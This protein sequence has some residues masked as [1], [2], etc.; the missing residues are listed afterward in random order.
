MLVEIDKGDLQR[1]ADGSTYLQ[2]I[3]L[4]QQWFNSLLLVKK[5]YL[6]SVTKL[7]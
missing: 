6:T 7:L 4:K 1:T 2:Q 5:L 3:T